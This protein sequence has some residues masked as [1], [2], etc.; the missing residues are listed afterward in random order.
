[1]KSPKMLMREAAARLM[2]RPRIDFPRPNLGIDPFEVLAPVAL[3]KFPTANMAR[4]A[5]G[6]VDQG[7]DERLKDNGLSEVKTLLGGA[8]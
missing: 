3:V 1:M 4:A 2:N 5:A 8:V 6:R 7:K